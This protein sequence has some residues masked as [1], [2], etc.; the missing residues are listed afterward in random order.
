[1]R[2]F[3]QSLLDHIKTLLGDAEDILLSPTLQAYMAIFIHAIN[4]V[5]NLGVYQ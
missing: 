2:I 3:N 5:Y 1:M 4:I